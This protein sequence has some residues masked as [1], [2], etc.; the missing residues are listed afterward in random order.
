MG[1]TILIWS[2]ETAEART[3]C[4]LATENAQMDNLFGF[5]DI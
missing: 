4:E 3:V 1:Q 5:L 2:I